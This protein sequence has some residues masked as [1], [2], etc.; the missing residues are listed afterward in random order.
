[1]DKRFLDQEYI[2]RINRVI[3]Y[4]ENNISNNLSLEELA[5]VANFSQY[6]FHR[7][8]GS[9]VG[10]TLFHFIQRIRVEKAASVLLTD[11]K[12]TIAEIA[13]CYGFSGPASF[14]RA[15]KEKFG[16]SASSYR[17]IGVA[18]IS[19][20]GKTDSNSGKT[21][22]NISNISSNSSWYFCGDNNNTQKWRY[23]MKNELE[24]NVEVKVLEEMT[25]AYVRHIGPYAGDEKLF[26]GLYTKLF[27]WAGPRGLLKFPQTKS[28]SVYHDDP[29][30]TAEGNL[31]TSVCI[32]VPE[33]TKVDGDIGKMKIAG[34]KYAIGKFEIN[35]DEFS[36]A[37]SMVYG[38]WMPQSGYQPDDGPS[39]ELCHNN[40]KD[41]PEGKFIV[42]I[43]IP[44]KAL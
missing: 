26:E 11:S 35:G 28:L 17:S 27:N 6:H 24:V 33:D 38:S 10:E 37:W 18:D 13:Y 9:I 31:R 2:S 15:F 29:K 22:S 36:K 39:F 8:F 25:V 20:R 44:V 4:I 41:H 42:S 19:N 12:K 23:D 3:D 14:A 34:G 30:I 21:K 32:T 7:I 5:R 16:M 43:C 1:M 40:P